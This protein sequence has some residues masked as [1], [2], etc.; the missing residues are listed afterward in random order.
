[1][2]IFFIFVSCSPFLSPV[3]RGQV[4]WSTLGPLIHLGI[5]FSCSL[6]EYEVGSMAFVANTQAP[7]VLQHYLSAEPTQHGLPKVT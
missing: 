5:I 4:S 2:S 6:I 3:G 1:M 7:S